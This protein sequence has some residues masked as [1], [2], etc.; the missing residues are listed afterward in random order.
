M[1][2]STSKHRDMARST[3]PSRNRKPARVAKAKTKRAARHAIRQ[4]LR[5]V[6]T[7]DDLDAWDEATDLH[8]QP[9]IEIRQLVL[10]RRDGDKLNHFERWAV[11]R[12]RHLRPE[13]R[14]SHLQ[15]LLPDG[16]IGDHAPSPTSAAAPS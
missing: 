16:L 11:A 5:A 12:T 4:E 2:A 6:S 14:L 7:L 10:H 3:L 15:A 13:D 9:S 1:R 8:R